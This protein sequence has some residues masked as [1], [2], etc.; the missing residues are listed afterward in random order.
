M[1]KKSRL[2]CDNV[3][4]PAPKIAMDVLSWTCRVKGND[5]AHRVACKAADTN[6]LPLGISEVLRS[7]RHYLRAQSQEYHIIDILVERRRKRKRSTIFF[8]RTRESAIVSQTSN[9]MCFNGNIT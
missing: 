9:R 7:L 3:L 6:G 1:E 8:E 4:Y 2:A 5:R